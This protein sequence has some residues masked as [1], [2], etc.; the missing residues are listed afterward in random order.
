MCRLIERRCKGE[1]TAV[2]LEP[3]GLGFASVASQL[4]PPSGQLFVSWGFYCLNCKMQKI[5]II[6]SFRDVLKTKLVLT[7]ADHTINS[8]MMPVY[9]LFSVCVCPSFVP[10]KQIPSP[11][12]FTYWDIFPLV[13]CFCKLPPFSGMSPYTHSR[14]H[15]STSSAFTYYIL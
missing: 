9:T 12:P 14:T 11:P 2:G 6:E 10:R 15:L 13:S 3:P 5:L 7:H 4:R 1:V 8:I